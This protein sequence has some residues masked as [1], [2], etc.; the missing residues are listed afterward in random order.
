[1]RYHG[2]GSMKQAPLFGGHLLN[3]GQISCYLIGDNGDKQ[4]GLDKRYEVLSTLGQSGTVS[5]DLP[6]YAAATLAFVL[7]TKKITDSAN[8]LA[9][10]LTGDTIR[11]IGSDGND[12]IYTVAI[13]GVAGEI[14]T[15]EALVDEAAGAYITIL[16]RASHSNNVVIDN[17]TGLMWA[18][19]V[20]VGKIGPA[21]DGKLNWYNA[22]T[23]F[24][25]HPADANVAM[26]TGNILRIVGSDESSRYFAGALL[27]CSGFANAINNLPGLRVVSVSF[28]G[29]NTDIVIDPGNQTLI[30]EAAGGSRAIKIICQNIFAYAAAINVALLGG[31]SDWRIPNISELQTLLNQEGVNA[32]PDPTAFP[33]WPT[34]DEHWSS[35]TRPIS[36]TLA[37]YASFYDGS[38]PVNLKTTTFFVA[39]VRGG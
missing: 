33:G 15:T 27:V 2:M 22:A 12:G 1:M 24:T 31:Y 35:T 20:Q 36:T 3:T 19:Y 23:C 29:G 32:S 4:N 13:G 34:T 28:T 21:S 37:I 9:T 38:S 30:A 7:G 39:L 6:H 10:V 11:I 18:R 5:V 14:M 25:L 16:K 8:G 17:N 26:V